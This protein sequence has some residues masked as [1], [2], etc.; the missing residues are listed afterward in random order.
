MGG[1]SYEPFSKVL[2]VRACAALKLY[3]P[4]VDSVARVRIHSFLEL[5]FYVVEKAFALMCP[6]SSGA[7]VDV[8]FVLF[9]RPAALACCLAARRPSFASDFVQINALSHF[10][11]RAQ[12]LH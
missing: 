11:P 8:G 12:E 7:V 2:K 4:G 1:W 9:F 3:D 5:R 10:S 6:L